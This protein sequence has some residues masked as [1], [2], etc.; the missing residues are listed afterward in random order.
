MMMSVIDEID[1]QKHSS[2]LWINEKYE[3]S[4][5][6]AIKCERNLTIYSGN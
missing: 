1:V 6:E 5:E 3:I 2:I 4:K